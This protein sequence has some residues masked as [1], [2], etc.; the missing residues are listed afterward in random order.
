MM[1]YALERQFESI[2]QANALG[3]TAFM[4]ELANRVHSV[5][6]RITGVVSYEE[7][8]HQARTTIP[9]AGDLGIT[10]VLTDYILRS[11]IKQAVLLQSQPPVTA[12][13]CEEE[14][15]MLDRVI[16][17]M[18]KHGFKTAGEALAFLKKQQLN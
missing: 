4:R 6:K 7:I 12:E 13:E 11:V 18:K 9:N 1:N 3:V 15:V 17:A 16:E 10:P 8:F 2:Y 14:L 5:M